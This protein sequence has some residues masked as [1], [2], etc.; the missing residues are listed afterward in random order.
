M[1]NEMLTV[2]ILVACGVCVARPSLMRARGHVFVALAVGLVLLLLAALA[3]MLLVLGARGLAAFLG[4]VA[5]GMQLVAV[6]LLVLGVSGLT[7]S[8]L[9]AEI[10]SG[11]RSFSPAGPRGFSVVQPESPAPPQP[12]NDPASTDPMQPPPQPQGI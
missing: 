4:G 9:L 3:S 1:G 12:R 5:M 8:D 6:V 7:L 2:A 10:I 11:L